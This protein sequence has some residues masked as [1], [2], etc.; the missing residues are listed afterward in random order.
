MRTADGRR[1]GWGVGERGGAGATELI[2]FEG[3]WRS[4]R[5]SDGDGA[6]ESGLVEAPSRQPR[7]HR[8]AAAQDKVRPWWLATFFFSLADDAQTLLAG[9]FRFR[10]QSSDCSL[11]QQLIEV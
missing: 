1:P 10:V 4:V 3:R 6:A 7:P 8:H 9:S 5:S 11:V 2:G